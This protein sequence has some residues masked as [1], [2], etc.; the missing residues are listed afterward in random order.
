MTQA[1]LVYP[2]FPESFWGHQRALE[3]LGLHASHPPLGLLT[4]AG[5]LPQDC[6][7]RLIDLNI[8]D[9]RPAD[10]AWADVVLTGGM[11]VQR[12]SVEWIIE[13]CEETSVPVV[14]GGPDVTSSHEQ[15]KGHPHFVLGEADT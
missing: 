6:D 10:L 14:V 5:M 11:M 15:I 9:L 3:F 8:T 13:R 7:T 1:L 2:K 4:I 12:P